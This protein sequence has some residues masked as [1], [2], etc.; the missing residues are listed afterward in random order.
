MSYDS[1][2]IPRELER[3]LH[4]VEPFVVPGR[5]FD[6]AIKSVIVII[7]PRSLPPDPFGVLVL[8]INTM[9]PYDRD[10]QCFTNLL[11][12]IVINN[13]TAMVYPRQ[14]IRVTDHLRQQAQQH[15]R[16]KVL[17]KKL[18]RSAP[19]GFAFWTR[20]NGSVYTQTWNKATWNQLFD[21]N[22][23]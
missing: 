7:V 15:E 18:G 13:I 5:G 14:M 20:I 6:A 1:G 12:S 10:H 16:V 9:R 17:S 4:L 22:A 23:D 3:F 19:F 2:Y 21:T 11:K 8:G